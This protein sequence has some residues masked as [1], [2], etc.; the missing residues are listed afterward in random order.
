MVAGLIYLAGGLNELNAEL[1]SVDCYN[2]VTKQ[3][4][5]VTGMKT[6]RAY[7]GLVALGGFLYAI[8][9]WNEYDGALASVE[10]YS[11]EEVNGSRN[12]SLCRF[13]VIQ[14]STCNV[15]VQL[16][17]YGVEVMGIDGGR[18]RSY[19]RTVC[20]TR[21]ERF[22]VFNPQKKNKSFSK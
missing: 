5:Y 2:P 7:F 3:W 17:V 18:P 12:T 8:G 11:I 1:R 16:S 9:G 10:R 13:L 14:L 22:R 15:H 21:I 6:K 20:L 4:S 19:S